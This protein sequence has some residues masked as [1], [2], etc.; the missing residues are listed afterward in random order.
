MNSRLLIGVTGAAGLV[1]D[2]RWR[3]QNGLLAR[4]TGTPQI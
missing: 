4:G 1:F 3:R 2:S